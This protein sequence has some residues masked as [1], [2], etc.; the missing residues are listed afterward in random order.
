M[1]RGYNASKPERPA[2]RSGARP[3]A[4]PGASP[5]TSRDDT[6]SQRAKCGGDGDDFLD[7][8]DRRRLVRCRLAGGVV[9]GAPDDRGHAPISQGTVGTLGLV[10]AG[11][12]TAWGF[13]SRLD[14][15]SLFDRG[16]AVR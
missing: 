5:P 3:G 4:Y 6:V 1:R 8:R 9:P 15:G 13:T 10:D 12:G 7:R 14:R 16:N 11:A 2:G